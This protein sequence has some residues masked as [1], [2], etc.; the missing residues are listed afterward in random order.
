[1]PTELQKAQLENEELELN[2]SIEEAEVHH[3]NTDYID[4]LWRIRNR[5]NMFEQ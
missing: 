4:A 5:T 2:D 1:M 3:H